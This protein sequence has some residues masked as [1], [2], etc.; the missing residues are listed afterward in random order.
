MLYSYIVVVMVIIHNA[1]DTACLPMWLTNMV[2]KD[3]I[4]EQHAGN[5]LDQVPTLCQ[6]M[7]FLG[8]YFVVVNLTQKRTSA[9]LRCSTF[10]ENLI[11]YYK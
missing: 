3:G 4:C 9:L 2:P 7:L 1:K 11:T 10:N 5:F 6:I 8:I